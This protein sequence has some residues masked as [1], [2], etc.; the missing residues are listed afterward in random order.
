[1]SRNL[2]S[3]LP[4][5]VAGSPDWWMDPHPHTCP[6][7]PG[8]PWAQQGGGDRQQPRLPAQMTREEGAGR[9]AIH[10]LDYNLSD[11]NTYRYRIDADLN[12]QI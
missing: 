2:G 12:F 5:G 9:A 4:G 11:L 1:M 10:I 8:I 6:A 7:T 3:H